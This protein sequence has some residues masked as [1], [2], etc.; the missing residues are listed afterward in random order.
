[1]NG[2]HISAGSREDDGAVGID[3]MGL[4][5]VVVPDVGGGPQEIVTVGWRG[6]GAAVDVDAGAW[7]KHEVGE[8]VRLR[9]NHGMDA[10]A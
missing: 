6:T 7:T 1:M 4:V 10:P 8:V 5:V 9:S 2:H 3:E